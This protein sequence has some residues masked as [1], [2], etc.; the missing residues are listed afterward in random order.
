MK[1]H[2]EVVELW[3]RKADEDEL[4]IKS[5]LK[6]KD[7]TPAAACFLAQQMA[8][9]YLK[10]LL[11]FAKNDLLKIH[12]L[13]K[14]AEVLSESFP[15]ISAIHD[16]ASML[17]GFYIEARYPGDFPEFSWAEAEEAY[18]SAKIIKKFVSGKAG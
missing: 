1:G 6:H 18:E 11:I 17:S 4:N 7:G 2:K 8:E 12:D 5:I 10:G 14:L 9:K 16:E 3:F 15:D 13:V